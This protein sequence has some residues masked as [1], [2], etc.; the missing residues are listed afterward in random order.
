[1]GLADIIG[2]FTGASEAV[3]ASNKRIAEMEKQNIEMLDI[4]RVQGEAV[5]EMRTTMALLWSD[6]KQVKAERDELRTKLQKYEHVVTM[7]GEIRL[8]DV[9]KGR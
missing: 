1:M 2:A 8:A 6:L 9:P 3:K 7:T 4:L 5:N